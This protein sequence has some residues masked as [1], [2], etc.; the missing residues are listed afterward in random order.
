MRSS[1]IILFLTFVQLLSSQNSA[2]KG[3]VKDRVTEIT[4]I[5]ATV[6]VLEN[7]KTSQGSATDENGKFTIE[8]LAPGRYNLRVSY[9]G[10][11]AVTIPNILVTSGKEMI[12]DVTMEESINALTEVVIS[13]N[14]DKDKPIN[15]MANI[16]ARTFSLVA[17]MMPVG[18]CLILQVS[19]PAMIPAM[20]L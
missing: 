18:W 13:A 20:I 7:N 12:L 16:S 17:E 15:E 10:Y 2:I 8:N 4:L 3:S 19:L 14:A 9:I 11:E 5:G 6:E 1:L